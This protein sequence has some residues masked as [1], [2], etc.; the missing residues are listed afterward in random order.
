V[1]ELL[2]RS[3][4][5]VVKYPLFR[6]AI[7]RIQEC[8]DSHDATAEPDC[9]PLVGESGCGKTTIILHFASLHPR[10]DHKWGVE[11]PVLV[12]KVPARTTVKS[13]AETLLYR[14]GDPLWSRGNTV[15]KSIRLREL[16]KRCKVRLLALDE[17]QHF[18]DVQRASVV[19]DVADWLKEQVEEARLAIVV[20]GLQ[21]CL[22][23]L[24]QNEQLRRRFS[25][26]LRV[27]AFRW[28]FKEDRTTYRAF[29]RAVQDQL[30]EYEMPSL[31]DLD[32]AFRLHYGSYGLI[33]YTMKIIRGAARIARCH[34]RRQ[35]TL[36]TLSQSFAEHVW[37]ERLDD[38]NPFTEKFDCHNA[39]PLTLPSARTSIPK[40]MG[41]N[42]RAHLELHA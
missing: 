15:S 5:I 32:M 29:L 41:R 11:V 6:M 25:A 27:G 8:F 33:G 16:V 37:A 17:F 36:R 12:A 28:E 39:P 30:P 40:E 2:D 31:S 34:P 26:T 22:E 9:C 24:R 35:I 18:V 38:P 42:R 10:V 19:N 14:L 7:A 21:R 4:R 20:A 3:E 1:T 23:V 13:F